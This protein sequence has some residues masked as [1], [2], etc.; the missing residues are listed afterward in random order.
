MRIHLH[1]FIPNRTYMQF[2]RIFVL[3]LL[4]FS[5]GL[6]IY[7]QPLT[8]AKYEDQIEAGD[9]SL[10]EGDFINA[11]EW[12][13]KAYKES[14]DR[15]L[16]A[17]KAIAQY[18]YRDYR[19]AEKSY[20][21]IFR[22][23]KKKQ[24]ESLR[25]DYANILIHNEKYTE[26]L[27]QIQMILA[28]GE[29]EEILMEAKNLKA[30]IMSMDQYNDN[31]EAAIGYIEGDVNSPNEE[32]SPVE[33]IDGTLYFASFNRKN[34]IT[35]DGNE[36]G[37]EC[38][39]YTTTVN[40][41][42]EYEKPQPLG[43]HIN[44]PGFHC[45]NVSFNK[46]GTVM[47]FTRSKFTNAQAES[48]RIWRSKKNSSGWSAAE[49]LE[50]V[51]GDWFATHPVE[52]ELFGNR[53]LFF[54]ADIPGGYGG[55]DIYYA[56]IEG[57]GFATPVNLG[58][59]I[60]T[61][62]TEKTPFYA[63]GTLYFS[64]DG[65]PGLGGL[66][67]HYSTWDGTVWSEV[68]NMGFNYNSSVDDM[69][70]RSNFN[71]TKAY[72]VSNRPDKKKRKIKSE[73]CCTDIYM[74]SIRDIVVDLLALVKDE[75]GPL[76]GATVE[77]MDNSVE[78]T[79]PVTKTNVTTND[80]S[81]IL[82]SDHDYT[83]VITKEGFYPDTI[84]FNTVGILDDYT[85]NKTV[86]LKA[87]PVEEETEVITINEPIRLNNIYYDFDKWDILPDAEDDLD[88]LIGIMD[89]YPDIVIELS[90]HTDARGVSTY[91]KSLSQKRAES[92]KY[93]MVSNGIDPDRIKPVGYGEDVILNQCKNGVR[94]TDD[95]HRLNR[96]TEFKIIEGPQTITVTKQKK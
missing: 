44:R 61:P 96:R 70:Y 40:K 84:T 58:E 7:A 13:D 2:S 85:V 82:E 88:Y 21:R 57:D 69:Y 27:K 16:A 19:R 62:F 91:N 22:R 60:N 18:G 1:R 59:R 94:C 15:G 63:D 3:T 39:I 14:R 66:D 35:L 79:P 5:F 50:T 23:D 51:N 37:Y 95:E 8:A 25:I 54:A 45:A 80:F 29:D 73:T 42:G 83:A 87:M 20:E 11:Y 4:M 46:E 28:N 93:Y 90:S 26:A 47:Y 56:T 38:K 31:L 33:Y 74:V 71:G 92:A 77:L 67:I 53:V 12:Y 64:S 86:T 36:E 17:L 9:S 32:Y 34:M 41:D 49:E 89:E 72:L 75:N 30:G 10:Y 52:G 81:F 65:Y 78:D 43:E 48:T 68:T 76:F 55:M 6:S 24:F